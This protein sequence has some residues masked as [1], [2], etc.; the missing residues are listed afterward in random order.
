MRWWRSGPRVLSGI[1]E[2]SDHMNLSFW[3]RG[4]ARSSPRRPVEGVEKKVVCEGMMA[5]D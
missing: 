5:T 4:R 1:R 3:H 2:Q